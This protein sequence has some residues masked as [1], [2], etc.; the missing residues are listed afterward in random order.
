[1]VREEGREE[2]RSVQAAFLS[3]DCPIREEEVER[4]CA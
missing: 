4:V 2:R 1:M 3:D